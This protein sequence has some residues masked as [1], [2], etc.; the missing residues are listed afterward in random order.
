MAGYFVIGMGVI[1]NGGPVLA[2]V[3]RHSIRRPGLERVLVVAALAVGL[4]VAFFLDLWTSSQI[5][6]LSGQS[7]ERELSDRA[8]AVNLLVLFGIY[9][10]IGGGL[11]LRAYLSER[12][13]LATFEAAR[14]LETLRREK[15]IADQKLELLQAQIE[16]H[17]LFNTLATVRSSIREEPA[18]AEATLDALCDYL[19]VTIPRL[20]RIDDPGGATLERQLEICERYLRVMQRRM[21]ERLEFS[22]AAN[23]EARRQPFPP[24]I[25]LSLVE[26]AIRH[27]LEPAAA[28]G[29]IDIR[30]CISDNRLAVIV[31]DTGVGLDTAIGNGVGLSNVREQLRLRYGE[32]ARLRLE[33][34]A[35]GGVRACIDIALEGLA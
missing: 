20:R 28:G 19:R 15:R 8:I 21:R 32:R 12:R 6:R 27:G 3:V 2:C 25:L 16:P 18:H 22:V 11:A 4:V 17:F 29:R 24:L 34:S 7:L 23:A 31:E 35:G 14:A 5:A 30:A 10:F 26:N 1:V 33:G 13:R 9:A